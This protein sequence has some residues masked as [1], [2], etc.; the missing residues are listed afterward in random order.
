MLFLLI[1]FFVFGLGL[2]D[3]SGSLFSLLPFLLGVVVVI[4][5]GEIYA[6]M[7]YNRWFY[8]FTK[9]ELR[10]EK[11]IIW[12]RYSNIPYERIQNVD[13]TRGILARILGFSTVNVQTAG[14]SGGYQRGGMG[15]GMSE[16]HIPAVSK[17]SAEKIRIWVMHRI[18][19]KKS[20]L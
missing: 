2:F 18:T 20:G 1:F 4:I 8:E 13:I 16:G 9:T 5:I 3:I 10:L 15:A 14:Y 17:E 12:K 6:R 7:S 19:G 11:G